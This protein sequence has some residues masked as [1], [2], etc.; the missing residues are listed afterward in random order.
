L[1]EVAR[2]QAATLLTPAS[3]RNSARRG[4]RGCGAT[5]EALET[6]ALQRHHAELEQA[7]ARHPEEGPAATGED[8]DDPLAIVRDAANAAL[9]ASHSPTRR[10]QPKIGRNDPCPCGSGK[11]FKLCHGRS[12]DE[13]EEQPTA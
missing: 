3:A 13:D 5:P 1:G 9:P 4:T 11:K 12:D 2:P 10:S 8:A 7:I 6:A